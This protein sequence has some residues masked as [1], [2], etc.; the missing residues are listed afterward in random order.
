MRYRSD[1]VSCGPAGNLQPCEMVDLITFSLLDGPFQK[2]WDE[3]IP[4]IRDIRVDKIVE[5]AQCEKEVLCGFCPAFFRLESGSEEIKSD[6]V[7]AMGHHR[8]KRIRA[9]RFRGGGDV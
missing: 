8:A 2:G 9:I 4:R 1:L 5:C 7:C 3:V 6:Y